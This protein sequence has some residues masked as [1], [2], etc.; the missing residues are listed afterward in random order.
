MWNNVYRFFHLY[1]PFSFLQ[2]P[3]EKLSHNNLI[4]GRPSKGVASFPRNIK[5]SSSISLLQWAERNYENRYNCFNLLK[6]NI[7]KRKVFTTHCNQPSAYP[8]PPLQIF[9]GDMLYKSWPLLQQSS[10]PPDRAHRNAWIPSR[11]SPARTL[12]LRVFMGTS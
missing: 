5:R 1:G 2:N 10:S 12:V 3:R 11:T 9:Q 8:G 7:Q 6:L 4:K